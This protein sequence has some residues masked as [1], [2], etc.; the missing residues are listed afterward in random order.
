MTDTNR[1]KKAVAIETSLLKALS[2]KESYDNYICYVDL[3]RILPE[4]Q[5]LLEDYKLYYEL[6][7]EHPQ[8]DFETFLTQFSSN[9]HR[10]DMTQEDANMYRDAIIRIKDSD[11]VEAES[12]LLGLVNKQFLDQVN[13]IGEKEFTSDDI[14]SLLDKYELKVAGILKEFDNDCMTSDEVDFDSID[15]SLGVPY[16]LDPLQD[17][18]GGMVNGSSVI[19]NAASGL[20]KTAFI[21]GQAVHTIKWAR[22]KKINRPVLIFTT[23]GTRSETFGRV[24]SN[25]YQDKFPGGY[26]E[27]LRN[28]E[29]IQKHFRE[30]GLRDL[31]YVF[32]G[33]SVGIQ[34]VRMKIKKYKPVLV[35]LDMAA[36]IA[37][38][39]SKSMSDTKLLE[40]FFNGLRRMSADNCPIISTVQAGAGAKW[41]DKDL[42]KYLYKQWPTDDDIYGSRTAVQGSAETIITI[43]RDN[44][45]PFTRYIQTTKKKAL[46]SAKFICEI[47]EKFSD[48]KLVD[49]ARS[50]NQEKDND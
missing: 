50:I 44:E 19:V 3:N 6:Y 41:W 29:K 14:R 48:Y 1:I 17:A 24:W 23:E 25:L 36:H 45:H 7:T 4:T 49:V 35:I 47:K 28:K 43:G 46:Q 15:K 32:T 20:G 8:I 42:Q 18:L 10:N 27:V 16:Y 33:N 9:W 39:D 34:Y 13:K 12:S 37:T 30:T 21:I 5:C 11:P 40:N 22:K 26:A 2:V 31:L 38:T